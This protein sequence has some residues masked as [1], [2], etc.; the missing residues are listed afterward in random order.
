[1]TKFN[2]DLEVG[3]AAGLDIP[4]ALALS[5]ESES[6]P[7]ENKKSG[8]LGVVILFVLGILYAV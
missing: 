2:E 8:C 7:P 5:A 4:T 3:L 6:K 1:M